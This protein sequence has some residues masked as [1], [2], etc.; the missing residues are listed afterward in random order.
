MAVGDFVSTVPAATVSG[1]S[2]LWAAKVHEKQN[3]SWAPNAIQYK[4]CM[5]IL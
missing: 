4:M 5:Y 3:T 2:F 1:M